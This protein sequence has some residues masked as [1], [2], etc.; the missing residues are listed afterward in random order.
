MT[1]RWTILPPYLP[2]A[3]GRDLFQR[4]RWALIASAVEAAGMRRKEGWV[5]WLK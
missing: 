1:V 3:E 4:L 5:C 2:S